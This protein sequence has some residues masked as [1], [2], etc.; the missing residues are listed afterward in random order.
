MVRQINYTDITQELGV[1]TGIQ[2]GEELHAADV[3]INW[4][5]LVCFFSETRACC[6]GCPT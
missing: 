4:Q 1:E 3:H 5:I 6:C 2:W